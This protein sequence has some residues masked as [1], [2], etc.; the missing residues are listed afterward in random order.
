MMD[1]NVLCTELV[2]NLRLTYQNPNGQIWWYGDTLKLLYEIMQFTPADHG[3]IPITSRPMTEEE[4]KE[5]I[6]RTG[7]RIE[8]DEAIIFMSRLPED[9][10]EVLTC[11]K[12][13]RISIDEFQDDPEYGCGFEYNGDMDGIVAWMPLPEPYRKEQT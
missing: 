2:K 12:Y 7:W 13:G 10:Q 8:P 9:G 6:E 3:W 5:Y 11:D 4:R 1:F